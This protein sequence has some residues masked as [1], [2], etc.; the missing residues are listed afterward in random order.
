MTHG[1]VVLFAWLEWLV[2]LLLLVYF[3]ARRNKE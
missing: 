3:V 1:L 2:L